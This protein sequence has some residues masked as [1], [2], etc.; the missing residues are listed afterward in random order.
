[1]LKTNTFLSNKNHVFEEGGRSYFQD[2]ES[3]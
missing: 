1:M 2:Q 3:G